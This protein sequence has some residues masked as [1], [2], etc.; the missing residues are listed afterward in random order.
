[1]AVQT[2][3]AAFSEQSQKKCHVEMFVHKTSIA[4][5]SETWGG[6]LFASFFLPTVN[7][8]FVQPCHRKVVYVPKPNLNHNG[9]RSKNSHMYFL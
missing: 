9:D 4:R 5:T 2:M 8:G 1:M 6:P 3:T 7:I